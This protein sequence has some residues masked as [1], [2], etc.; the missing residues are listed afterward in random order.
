MQIFCKHNLERNVSSENVIQILEAADKAQIQ[1]QT[2]DMKSYALNL[3]V[4]NF[5]TVVHNSTDQLRNLSRDLLLDILYAMAE[6]KSQESSSILDVP[7]PRL[8]S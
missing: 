3:I 5:N 1:C 4:K 2:R 7:G 6:E 8:N